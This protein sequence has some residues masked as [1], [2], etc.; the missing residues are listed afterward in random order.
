MKRQNKSK[1]HGRQCVARVQLQTPIPEPN[2][3]RTWPRINQRA[4]R[5]SRPHNPGCLAMFSWRW[6][7][8]SHRPESICGK[9]RSG[10]LTLKRSTKQQM[11]ANTALVCNRRRR[12]QSKM[13]I[14]NGPA[15]AG[16]HPAR[17]GHMDQKSP[18]LSSSL[19]NGRSRNL[20]EPR[21][22]DSAQEMQPHKK[23]VYPCLVTEQL[24]KKR[25]RKAKARTDRRL[26]HSPSKRAHDKWN[27]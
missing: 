1:T 11:T 15:R 23:K 4:P 8:R 5:T 27:S 2:G 3:K 22:Y 25:R 7:G 24:S 19:R 13:V 9:I 20:E 26:L 12:S 6:N 10:S 14:I 17:A 18:A 16:V 21:P